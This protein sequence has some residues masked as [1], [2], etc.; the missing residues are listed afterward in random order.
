MK[1]NNYSLTFFHKI[2]KLES[3]WVRVFLGVYI[4]IF[5][6]HLLE[7]P[8]SFTWLL[9]LGLS[10]GGGVA[11]LGHLKKTQSLHW[12][13][14]LFLS[15]HMI[16]ELGHFIH[17]RH[18]VAFYV[19]HIIFDIGFLYILAHGHVR[20]FSY[21]LVIIVSVGIIT[22]PLHL[23]AEEPLIQG[24]IYGGIFVCILYH[25]IQGKIS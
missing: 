13:T 11:L 6:I 17:H 5:A 24:V 21:W 15:V 20:T 9:V 25:F 3:I 4:I 18:H 14:P 1:L 8:F 7:N 23:Q 16:L 2:K 12:I 19:L 10:I 22:A